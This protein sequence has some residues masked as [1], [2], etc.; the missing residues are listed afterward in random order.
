MLPRDNKQDLF[1]FPE[2][3]EFLTVPSNNDCIIEPV[4][5][6]SRRC[7]DMCWLIL[8]AGSW[9][10][11]T[12]V[13][14][15][16][17]G[18]INTVDKDSVFYVP[19]GN[20]ERLFRGVDYNGKMCGVDKEVVNLEKK[21]LPNTGAGAGAGAGSGSNTVSSSSGF[22]TPEQFGICVMDCP[23]QGE[24][25]PDPYNTYGTWTAIEDVREKIRY[26]I[27]YLFI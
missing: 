5:Y 27:C 11:M 17:T 9:F 7:T 24:L 10:L 18:I 19:V 4:P 15:Q 13:G 6:S 14:F 20:P 21:W 1:I 23:S 26:L 22:N 16:V 2:D 12:L 25:V 8:L 3:K